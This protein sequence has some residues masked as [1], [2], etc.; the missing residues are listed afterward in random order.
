M[1]LM[2]LAINVFYLNLRYHEIMYGWFVIS[3]KHVIRYNY[4]L[5]G[6]QSA[7][8]LIKYNRAVDPFINFIQNKLIFIDLP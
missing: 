7:R 4:C 2:F 5:Q 3:E 8:T 1:W 6:G